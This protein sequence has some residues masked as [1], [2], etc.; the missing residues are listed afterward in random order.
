[1]TRPRRDYQ[2]QEERNLL[3]WSIKDLASHYNLSESTV[4]TLVSS[5]KLSCHRFGAGRGTV[6]VSEEE[7]LRWE[8]SSR[9]NPV[10]PTPPEPRRFQPRR[11]N[12]LVRKHFG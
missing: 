4:Y 3:W 6:R 7:R 9:S 2:P 1:M 11:E 8:T 12:D 5:G 10:K